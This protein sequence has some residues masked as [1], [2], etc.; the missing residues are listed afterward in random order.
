MCQLQHAAIAFSQSKS[1]VM[2]PESMLLKKFAREQT[3]VG[4]LFE[5][6]IGD[7]QWIMQFSSSE[8][9]FSL[10]S[11]NVFFPRQLSDVP[12]NSFTPGCKQ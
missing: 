2:P 12:E 6:K 10:F 7:T 8:C 3:L 5:K 1:Y 9:V 4:S 11:Q